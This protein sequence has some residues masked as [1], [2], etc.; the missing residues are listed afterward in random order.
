MS[1]N[2]P[3]PMIDP[4]GVLAG[5]DEKPQPKAETARWENSEVGKCPVCKQ[6]M[7]TLEAAG[8]SS[9][10]CLEHHIALPVQD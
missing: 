5:A 2:K 7:R 3:Q 8:I 4:L 1:S 10:V 6:Q 9:Y